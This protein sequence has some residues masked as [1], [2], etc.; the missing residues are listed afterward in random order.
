MSL[1]IELDEKSLESYVF[2]AA[3]T[4]SK[5]NKQLGTDMF[6]SYEVF[7]HL[8]K[9]HPNLLI[10]EGETSVVLEKFVEKKWLSRIHATLC[11]YI[12]NPI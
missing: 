5:R 10:N 2:F 12:I 7:A 4:V 8:Q 9:E 3:Y 11:R 6:N 1:K